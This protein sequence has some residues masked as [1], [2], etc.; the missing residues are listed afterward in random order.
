VEKASRVLFSFYSSFVPSVKQ[1]WSLTT[2]EGS[3]AM[4]HPGRDGGDFAGRASAGGVSA[5]DR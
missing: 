3:D 5:G 1:L 4:D 2:L